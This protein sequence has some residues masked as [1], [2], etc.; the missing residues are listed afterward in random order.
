MFPTCFQCYVEVS[1]LGGIELLGG[2][3]VQLL[4]ACKIEPANGEGAP[5]KMLVLSGTK[6][7]CPV[8][9]YKA[10]Y[11]EAVPNSEVVPC[12]KVT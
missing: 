7:L 12:N 10:T 11:K 1:V 4:S 2:R 6:C 3:L 5:D 9:L 8:L